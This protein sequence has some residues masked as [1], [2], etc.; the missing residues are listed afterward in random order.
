[1]KTLTQTAEVDALFEEPVAILVKHSARCPISHWAMLELSRFEQ[2]F[3][4]HQVHV[5]DVLASRPLSAYVAERTSVR[6]ESPQVLVLR[7]GEL[8]WSA[9]HETITARAVART[10]AN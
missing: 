2:E 1:M 10:L 4:E 5:V 3:P 8:A 9:S 7:K 6:H